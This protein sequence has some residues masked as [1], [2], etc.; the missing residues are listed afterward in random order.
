[1]PWYLLLFKGDLLNISLNDSSVN[2][3][4]SFVVKFK[5]CG[6]GVNAFSIVG[7]ENLFQGQ[8]SWQVSHP[9]I[10]L[11]N[12]PWKEKPGK[13]ISFYNSYHFTNGLYN[14]I[15]IGYKMNFKE[16]PSFLFSAGYSYK[17]VNNKIGVALACLVPP[18]PEEFSNYEYGYGRIVLKAGIDLRWFNFG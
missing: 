4:Q 7:F 15:G 16:S 8:T 18:C 6:R 10:Q 11:S 2:S 5:I 14:D 9:N 13:E 17:K 1:M 3:S 12:F